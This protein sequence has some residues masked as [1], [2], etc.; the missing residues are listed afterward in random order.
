MGDV[1]DYTGKPNVACDNSLLSPSNES[2]SWP[3]A[4]DLLLIPLTINVP[5]REIHSIS[6]VSDGQ[7]MFFWT[8]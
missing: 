7:R 3:K 6:F 1:H 4:I 5:G 2:I 8:L